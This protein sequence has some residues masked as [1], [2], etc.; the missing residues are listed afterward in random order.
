MDIM[1]K[2]G[3]ELGLSLSPNELGCTIADVVRI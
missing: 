3:K 2:P 1:K